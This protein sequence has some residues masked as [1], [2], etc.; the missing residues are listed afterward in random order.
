LPGPISPAPTP[1]IE[2]PSSV[3]TPVVISDRGV[4]ATLQGTSGD[5]TFVVGQ[6][7]TVVIGGAG[8]DTVNSSV[9][10]VMSSGVEKLVL[11]G[12][13][14]TCGTGTAANDTILGN[15]GA[16]IL[17]GN[18]GDDR[19]TG[20]GG[21]DTL[22][23]GNG[24]DRLDGGTGSD[25]LFGEAGADQLLGGA[26]N[27]RL[28]GGADADILTGGEGADVFVF[29]TLSHSRSGTA[30]LITD[31]VSGVDDL[32]LTALDANTKVL[33]NQ[34]F[35]WGG[36]GIGQLSVRDGHLVADVNG[37]GRMDFDLDLRG[38]LITSSDV[39]L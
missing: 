26:G 23:G 31:F 14:A 1:I 30:D 9:S 13:A 8:I 2:T 33:G 17:K 22:K 6:K 36:T 4:A 12:T 5:D 3:V 39:L 19:L 35:G 10:W 27:D 18:S 7:A 29:G 11:T 38:A 21:A 24:A 37:D 28:N 34:A 32:D 20:S 16:N 25:A 15:E